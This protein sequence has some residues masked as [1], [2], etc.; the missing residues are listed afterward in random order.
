M[1]ASFSASFSE[2]ARQLEV[3]RSDKSTLV[4]LDALA[5]WLYTAFKSGNKVL[6]CGNGG[7]MADA[8]HFSEEWTGRFRNDRDPLPCARPVRSHPHELCRERLWF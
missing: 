7:S 3:F 1:P 6:A 2:A 8:M 5:D 4:A